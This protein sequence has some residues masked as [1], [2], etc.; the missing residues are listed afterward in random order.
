MKRNFA[1]VY[2]E[3]DSDGYRVGDEAAHVAAA[4]LAQ[5]L[6][7]PT[8]ARITD[9]VTLFETVGGQVYV[10]PLRVQDPDDPG[11]Y[12]V[13]ALVFN[14]E[15]RDI[16]VQKFEPPEEVLGVPVTESHEPGV[17]I[18]I[19]RPEDLDAEIREKAEAALATAEDTLEEI[20]A[21]RLAGEAEADPDA[22]PLPEEPEPYPTEV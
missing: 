15:T 12:N 16:K 1:S 7:A 4:A 14:Y 13:A 19:E 18:E 11:T 17:E 8:I 10:T 9:M 2:S 5:R 20:A 22:E 6:D 21:G 3:N